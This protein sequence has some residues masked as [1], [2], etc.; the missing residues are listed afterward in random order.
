ME[1]K[2]NCTESPACRQKCAAALLPFLGGFIAA[3]VL[4]WLVIPSLLFDSETQPLLF[5]HATHMKKAGAVCLD[6]HSVRSDGSFTGI[7]Q[8]DVCM[9]CHNGILTPEPGQ[10]ASPVE[11]AAYQAEKSFVENYLN[12]G[13]PVPWRKHQYQPQNVFF[14]HPA[15]FQKCYTCHLTMQGRLNLGTPENPQKL[16]ATC[17]VSLEKLDRDAPVETNIL[18]GYSSGTLKMSE[19]ERCHANPGHFYADGRGRT[20][21]NNACFTCHK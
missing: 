3:L 17:H 10:G 15:H 8:N 13:K 14:S 21:A 7:P 19:C 6:C 12:P 11:K 1:E 5:S 20:F 2:T 4:G 9:S 16:C 18:T